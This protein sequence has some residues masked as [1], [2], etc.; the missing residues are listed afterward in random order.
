MN[1]W[2]HLQ[3]SFWGKDKSDTDSDKG[4]PSRLM[5]LQSCTSFYV[6]EVGPWK[7][8]G[9]PEA[10]AA[11]PTLLPLYGA[12]DADY[13]HRCGAG[14]MRE[15]T[16]LGLMDGYRTHKL[17]LR[18]V[19][20]YLGEIG[21]PVDRTR[22]AELRTYVQGELQ[23]IQ[24]E[25]QRLLP[26]EVLSVH[27]KAGYKSANPKLAFATD[28]DVKMPLSEIV[29]QQTASGE[30]LVT[31]AGHVGY[32]RFK[33]FDGVDGTANWEE[34]WCVERL[35]NPHGSS[36]NTKSYIRARGYR[37]PKKIGTEDDTTGKN[38]LKRLADETADEV[39]S[40]TINWRELAKTGN[41]Y[42]S[43]L[44][45]PGDDGRVHA[46][47][48]WGTA[49]GQLVAVRPAVMTY[50]EHSEI[51][52]MAKAAIR[53]QPGH[54][55]VKVD[56]RGFH[57][58]AIG[59]L[60][61]DPAYYKLADFDVHSFITAHFLHLHDAPYLLEMDDDELRGAL[62]AIKTEHWHTLNYKVKRCVHGRQFNMGVNKLYDMHSQNFDPPAERMAEL[63][64]PERWYNWDRKR[65]L[66]E[67]S[68]EGRREAR[69]L[70]NL[71]DK[72][73]PATFVVYPEVVANRLRNIT[74]WR[75]T[76]PFGHHRFFYDYDK[77]QSTAFGPSNCAH[78]H[79][80]AAMVRLYRSGALQRYECV[81]FTHDAAWFHPLEE[82]VAECIATAQAEFDAP[83]TVLVDSPLGPFQ[84][85]SDAE[86]GDD[87]AHMDAWK[88]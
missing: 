72:L 29:A 5:G 25:I 73:F 20:D 1:A 33:R 77:E 31:A 41:D 61:N 76:T 37:M 63:V 59:W 38:E 75:L 78:C 39:L 9:T 22:Q 13:T 60:A 12:Y 2:G 10:I 81:N 68:R 86:V 30:Q 52:K 23:R 53:A 14:I 74:P 28:P 79:I 85:N 56:M 47:F 48:R 44:W 24:T 17:D 88:G 45:V 64:G 46:E 18:P 82:L 27:P 6:P 40:L 87:L 43:G 42:T 32:L 11:D 3:P 69:A 65:Q 83:S 54:K 57:A 71:F 21:L 4:V 8:L 15:L 7:H 55:L 36:P 58:R 19:L 62:A 66:D 49:S 51:A 34:R 80:Q 35:Y 84:C 26:A 50:P 67:A 16:A 70:F